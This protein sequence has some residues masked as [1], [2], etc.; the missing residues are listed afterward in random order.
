V[1]DLGAVECALPRKQVV[2]EA[3]RVE[4][5]PKRALGL[6]PKLVGA[7][8]FRGARRE[9]VDDLGE[10][11]VRVDLL[12]QSRKRGDFRLDLFLGAKNVAVILR[13]SAD[14]HDAVQSP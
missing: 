14:T 11:E 10:A 8:P 13:E 3:A 2:D 5:C 6:I 1:F 4:G 7:D 9:L 12:Q